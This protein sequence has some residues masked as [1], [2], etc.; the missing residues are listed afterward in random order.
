MAPSSIT[1]ANDLSPI[2]GAD[3]GGRG[4]L[5]ERWLVQAGMPATAAVAGARAAAER[6]TRFPK[7]VN[8]LWP[9]I[10]WA[11]EWLAP[12]LVIL[13]WSRASRLSDRDLDRLLQRIRT[14]RLAAIR[15]VAI[16]AF[17][18]LMEVLLEEPRPA[19]TP[20]PLRGRLDHS[21]AVD[22]DVLVIGTGAG[23]APVGWALSQK[24][25]RVGFVDKG[26]LVDA[27]TAP[28]AVEKHYISQAMVGSIAGGATLVMAGSSIGGT[29]S[30]NSGTC[31]RAPKARLEEWDAGWGTRFADGAL[32]PY[33]DEV[34]RAIG[35]TVPPRSLLSKS[36]AIIERGFEAIGRDGVYVLPRN[37]PKC[38]GSGRCCFGCPPQAKRS[39][40]HAFLPAALERGA[41][42][43]AGTVATRIVEEQDEVRVTLR[44]A[45]GERV[46]RCRHLV[47]AGGA[48]FTPGLL[49]RNRLGRHW[50]RA[51]KCF[52]T[53]PAT[54]L[55]A[56]FP[57]LGHGEGGVPQGLGYKPPDLPR[58]TLE[59]IHTPRSV[60]A[61]IM[62]AAGSQLS[63]WLD[64]VDDL[65]SFGLM[66]RDR[67]TGR[68]Y[69]V[70]GS[71]FI[72]YR[73][74]RDD[75]RELGT[76]ILMIAE[77]FFAAGAQR[78]LLPVAGMQN[79]YASVDALRAIQ[80]DDFTAQGMIISGFHPQ[81]TA[82]IGRVVDIDLSLIGSDR[83]SVCDASVLPDSPGV[84][85]MVTIMALSLRL[86]ER[87]AVA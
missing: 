47:V 74:H 70:G 41:D 26:G 33:L 56:H 38:V 81:G 83:I 34:E 53:H 16:L 23:G 66:Q 57:G 68:V 3:S 79:E 76:G 75:V 37:A 82:G 58:T 43:M 85:P 73:L 24:G 65:A 77:A 9:L 15:A 52:K 39:T 4:G 86:A 84:N 60:V 35:V 5:A 11:L 28:R 27:E 36:A 22:Y 7:P 21:R 48:L 6:A 69:E 30:I 80:P 50:R 55:F 14:H 63:W 40:D 51:G 44:D 17:N 54:K 1:T 62:S 46:V 8:R 20:H 59:G 45:D 13:R 2:A 31:L 29:T 10:L 18:P 25:L 72:H 64:H 87:L 19:G 78:V 71:P 42:I 32:D 61:P 49:R 12:L 67:N